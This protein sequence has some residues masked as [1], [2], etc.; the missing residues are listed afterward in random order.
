MIGCRVLIADLAEGP[1]AYRATPLTVAPVLC[2][3]TGRQTAT[4]L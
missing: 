2:N 4:P 3:T 1:P